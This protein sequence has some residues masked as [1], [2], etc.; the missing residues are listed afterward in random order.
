M[1]YLC[2]CLHVLH[3]LLACILMADEQLF[4]VHTSQRFIRLASKLQKDRMH[5]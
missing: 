5:L 3:M 1:Q 4:Q 2:S